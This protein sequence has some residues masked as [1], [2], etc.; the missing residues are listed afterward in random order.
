[1][2]QGAVTV[3]KSWGMEEGLLHILAGA[4]DGFFQWE[5]GAEKGS[6]RGGEGAASAV[7]MAG[8]DAR[9]F[10]ASG[11]VGGYQ[12]IDDRIACEMTALHKDGIGTQFAYPAGRCFHILFAGD[13]HICE[14]FRFGN[15]GSDEGGEGEKL[16]FQRG[17]GLRLQQ[18]RAA[19]G[20]H[21]GV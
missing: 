2:A 19:L 3:T 1:M 11:F 5:S 21:D 17:Y 18:R 14:D 6:D 8:I 7:G 15:I 13:R 16:S 12:Q 10:K 9:A 20:D 4:G